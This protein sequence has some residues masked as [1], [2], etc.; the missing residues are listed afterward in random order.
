[1]ADLICHVLIII[2]IAKFQILTE[3]QI[4]GHFDHGKDKQS[5]QCFS[6]TYQC[7]KKRLKVCEPYVRKYQHCHT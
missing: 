2:T 6:Y 4:D 5:A 1:M 3:N 7:T